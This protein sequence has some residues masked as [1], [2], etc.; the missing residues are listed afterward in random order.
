LSIFS[1]W[2]L[3]MLKWE[4]KTEYQ[5]HD[6]SASLAQLMAGARSATSCAARA[7]GV[8]SGRCNGALVAG[9]LYLFA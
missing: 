3:K 4:I 7:V 6:G 2:L 5:Q 8:W 9:L 1:E